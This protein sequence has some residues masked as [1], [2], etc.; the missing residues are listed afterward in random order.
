M[1]RLTTRYDKIVKELSINVKKI[2]SVVNGVTDDIFIKRCQALGNNKEFGALNL[3]N[4]DI[5]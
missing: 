5:C 3:L 2:F 1:D 4:D